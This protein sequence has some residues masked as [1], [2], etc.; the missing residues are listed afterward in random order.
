MRIHTHTVCEHSQGFVHSSVGRSDLPYE[1]SH[2]PTNS[3]E[4]RVDKIPNHISR[5]HTMSRNLDEC[6][7]FVHEQKSYLSKTELLIQQVAELVGF[8]DSIDEKT[9][10]SHL[11]RSALDG[12]SN[13]KYKNKELFGYGH[14]TPIRI[15]L[16]L[17]RKRQSYRV[18]VVPLLGQPGFQALRM[19]LSVN[20]DVGANICRDSQNEIFNLL[21]GAS[22][23]EDVLLDFRKMLLIA[24]PKSVHTN[25][26]KDRVKVSSL[27]HYFKTRITRAFENGRI[28]TIAE[29]PG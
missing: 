14:E 12:Y 16:Y 9:A 24:E 26:S 28:R 6:L 2:T 15:H 3:L 22:K 25:P 19:A 18:P 21:L 10:K 8:P 5:H 23:T 17:D 27:F 20:S 1:C 29:V 4:R 11:L 13:H 7:K